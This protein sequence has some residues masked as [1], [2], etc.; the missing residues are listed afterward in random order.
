MK[1]VFFSL[2]F[3]CSIIYIKAQCN[4]GSVKEGPYRLE[5]SNEKGSLMRFIQWDS[6]NTY[7]YSNCQLGIAEVLSGR[8]YVF[9]YDGSK[10]VSQKSIQF[11]ASHAK[12]IKI[13]GNKIKVIYDNGS[14]ETKDINQY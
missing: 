4:I 12:S 9:L 11:S 8:T 10:N 3:V 7:D 1:K 13:I 14:E 6:K 5:V 2:I